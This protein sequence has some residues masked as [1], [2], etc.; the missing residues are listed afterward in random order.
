M[1][2]PEIISRCIPRQRRLTAL[3]TGDWAVLWNN[4]RYRAVH[5]PGGQWSIENVVK[6]GGDS[7]FGFDRYGGVAQ[8]Y[9]LWKDRLA[10]EFGGGLLPSQV[11]GYDDKNPP[12][13]AGHGW[14]HQRPQTGGA[15]IRL[16]NQ[17]RKLRREV[18]Q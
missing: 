15:D 4:P 6:V 11:T 16:P 14:V 17:T 1:G 2:A 8:S 9:A 5:G 7:Y 12:K 18:I 10:A 3:K 13:S